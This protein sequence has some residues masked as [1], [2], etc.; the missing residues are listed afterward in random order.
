MQSAS[1]A[2]KQPCVTGKDPV[3]GSGGA[4]TWGPL[5]VVRTGWESPVLPLGTDT[6]GLDNS[7]WHGTPDAFM[8]TLGNYPLTSPVSPD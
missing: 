7:T 6:D 5:G 8:Q 1:V 2:V 3:S 4:K